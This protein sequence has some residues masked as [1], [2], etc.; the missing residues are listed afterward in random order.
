MKIESSSF[1]KLPD[2]SNVKLFTLINNNKLSIKIT[3]YGAII[4][5]VEMLLWAARKEPDNFTFSC[6]DRFVLTDVS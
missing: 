5:S 6:F 4:T 2:G 1:G 3:N